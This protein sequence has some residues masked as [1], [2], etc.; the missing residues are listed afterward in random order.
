MSPPR[1]GLE[2]GE[3]DGDVQVRRLPTR[4][5]KILMVQG[6]PGQVDQRIGLPFD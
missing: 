1:P 2:L 3:G 4:S 6:E 5:G